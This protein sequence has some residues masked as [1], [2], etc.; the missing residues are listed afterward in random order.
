MFQDRT[1]EEYHNVSV[2]MAFCDLHLDRINC[3]AV[4]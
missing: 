1:I 3:M 2:D 4:S